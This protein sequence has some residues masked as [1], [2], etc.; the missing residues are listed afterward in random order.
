MTGS[1][2]RTRTDD[3]RIK[4]P[5][6]FRL[7]YKGISN[8]LWENNCGWGF[9]PHIASKIRL[10]IPTV[11]LRLNWPTVAASTIAINTTALPQF[12]SIP[13]PQLFHEWTLMWWE[14]DSNP[15][16]RLVKPQAAI[17]FISPFWWAYWVSNP[18]PS[19][20]EPDALT[21]WAIGPHWF[22]IFI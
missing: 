20:Y 17:Y 3:P 9:A 14:W 10:F 4:N 13:P 8:Y 16:N 2:G 12:V 5:L 22:L 7:S 6:L 1:L 11:F 21:N 18:G 19:G 15:H